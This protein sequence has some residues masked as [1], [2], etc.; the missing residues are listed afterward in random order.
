MRSQVRRS[1]LSH[2]LESHLLSGRTHRLRDAK[3]RDLCQ[4]Q[5]QSEALRAL[6]PPLSERQGLPQG[7]VP[8]PGLT[9]ALA[10]K[11]PLGSGRAPPLVA[12]LVIMLAMSC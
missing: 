7:Q 8:G 4:Y 1:H 3:R 11:A 10:F 5:A 6:Q 2:L 9:A 12:P